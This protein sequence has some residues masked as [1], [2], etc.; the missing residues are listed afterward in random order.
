MVL[1]GVMVWAPL[2]PYVN[3]TLLS[4]QDWKMQI[5]FL[6]YNIFKLDWSMQIG[7]EHWMSFKILIPKKY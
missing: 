1:G 2:L 4:L 5:D 6:K 7:K 3:L